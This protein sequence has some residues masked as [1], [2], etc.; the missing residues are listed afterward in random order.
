MKNYG[1]FWSVIFYGSLVE[2]KEKTWNLT[3]D[4][5]F[6]S[7]E[8]MGGGIVNTTVTVPTAKGVILANDASLLAENHGEIDLSNECIQRMMRRMGFVKCKSSTGAKVDPEVF[9]E[10]QGQYL[11]DI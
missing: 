11:S 3:L 6:V 4:S 8:I 5:F 9:K 7:G 2:R 1:I 10:L